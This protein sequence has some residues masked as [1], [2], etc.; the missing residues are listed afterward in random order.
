MNIMA[1]KIDM[2]NATGTQKPAKKTTKS[3]R[4]RSGH[5]VELVIDG[6]VVVFLPGKTVEVPM[7]FQIPGGLGLF[8]R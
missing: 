3:V 4:N 5:R 7:D 2:Q 6:K 8:V 1:E